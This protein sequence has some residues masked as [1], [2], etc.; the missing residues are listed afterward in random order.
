M[1]D[2]TSDPTAEEC[3]RAAASVVL[4]RD[5]PQGL[6]VLL[7]RRHAQSRVLGGLYVF[8]GGKVDDDDADPAWAP[9]L[10]TPAA[11]LTVPLA[12][13]ALSPAQAQALYVAAAREL[14]EE[15]GVALV[16][17]PERFSGVARDAAALGWRQ[18]L[19]A[20][21]VR[22]RTQALRPWS[23]WITPRR[24]PVGTPRF[25]TRFF[26]ARL[27][28][29]GHASHD[30]REMTDTLWLTPR[31]ALQRYWAREIELIPPQLM[32]LA[33]LARHADVASAWAAAAHR[34]PPCILPETFDDGGERAICYPG[35]ARHPVRERALPGPTR[36]RWVGGRFEP[37]DGFEGWFR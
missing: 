1:N 26:L 31:Q 13:P 10:D 15:A 24:P 9:L 16:D 32:G 7:Q 18:M 19:V 34:T 17:A 3:P 23:R 11:A 20:A 37:Y 14:W 25:D 35:D 28:A 22:L 29:G 4:L 2:R 5:G 36:L 8:P 30:A 6:E 33:E 21:G 12:E 27:P